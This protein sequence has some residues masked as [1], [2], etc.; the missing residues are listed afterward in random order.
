MALIKKVDVNGYFAAK[1]ATRLGRLGMVRQPVTAGT[2]PAGK[3]KKTP[4]VN[5]NRNRVNSSPSV[6]AIVIPIVAGFG[7]RRDSA[8]PGSRKE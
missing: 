5:G 3:A 6:P 8:L 1:R 7:V 2:V 4:R